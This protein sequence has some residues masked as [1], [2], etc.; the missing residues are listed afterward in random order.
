MN[1]FWA[2]VVQELPRMVLA[3]KKKW[4]KQRFRN[5]CYREQLADRAFYAVLLVRVAL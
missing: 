5:R 1:R 2:S 3:D 4:Q